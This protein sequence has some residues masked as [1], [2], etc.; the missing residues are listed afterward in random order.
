MPKP[1]K[2][3]SSSEA[4]YQV[5]ESQQGLFT[6]KQA[7]QAGYDERNHPYHVQS[8]HW[9]REQRGIYRLRDFPYSPESQLC[10]WSLWTCDRQGK[11]QGVYSH[12]TA[13]QIYSLS[14]LSPSKLH[15]TV[16][17]YFRKSCLIP[18]ILTIH[19][20]NLKPSDWR[21]MTGFYV[22][23]PTRTLYDIISSKSVSE[24]FIAQI[25]K[26]GQA[27]GLF[28]KPQLRKYK[29]LKKIKPYIEKASYAG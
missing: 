19:K 17:K 22:T 9:I 26:E 1:K 23:T 5:A 11:A 13:L 3:I 24:E 8:G 15:I 14:D 7:V 20:D 16:P 25:I 6:A 2:R 28:P 27:K 12:E 29:L 21:E 10:L 4:L 18:K